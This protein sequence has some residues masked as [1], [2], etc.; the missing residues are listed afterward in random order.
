MDVGCGG[1]STRPK[2]VEDATHPRCGRAGDQGRAVRGLVPRG[3]ERAARQCGASSGGVL[4]GAFSY[5]PEFAGWRPRIGNS[6]L[7]GASPAGGWET[8]ARPWGRDGSVNAQSL[9]INPTAV[10]LSPTAVHQSPMAVHPIQRR[11]TTLAPTRT[12]PSGR[13]GGRSSGAGCRLRGPATQGF[14]LDQVVLGTILRSCGPTLGKQYSRL[15]GR[16]LIARRFRRGEEGRAPLTSGEKPFDFFQELPGVARLGQEGR[17]SRVHGIQDV[18]RKRVGGQDKN[19]NMVC[20][21]VGADSTGGF[22][23]IH[24]RHGHVHNDHI[25]T[26][27]QCEWKGFRPIHCLHNHMLGIFQHGAVNLAIVTVI[28]DQQN[29]CHPT[30]L[31][32]VT[33]F[34]GTPCCKFH[35]RALRRLR[36]QAFTRCSGRDGRD[37][38]AG[39]TGFEDNPANVR[40]KLDFPSR[41]IRRQDDYRNRGTL[42]VCVQAGRDDRPRCGGEPVIQKDHVR[43]VQAGGIAGVGSIGDG[44]NRV[45]CLRK[46]C[47]ANH[48]GICVVVY[49]Q[50]AR[51]CHWIAFA[52]ETYT[53]PSKM[54]FIECL[55]N[56]E[57]GGYGLGVSPAAQGPGFARSRATNNV[58]LLRRATPADRCADGLQRAGT[59]CLPGTPPGCPGPAGANPSRGSSQRGNDVAACRGGAGPVVTLA[60]SLSPA[61][62]SSLR[63]VGRL[64]RA[65]VGGSAPHTPTFRAAGG[66][67]GGG[68][69]PR[70]APVRGLGWQDA[71]AR[72][73]GTQL[74]HAAGCNTAT[75]TCNNGPDHC[76]GRAVRRVRE[77]ENIGDAYVIRTYKT[78]ARIA[79]TCYIIDVGCARHRSRRRT[80]HGAEY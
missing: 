55:H 19:G 52:A 29:L 22:Q 44:R 71:P 66:S 67:G 36:G 48:N 75:P 50:H 80:G 9:L 68:G 63:R 38:P 62:A 45:A 57:G 25:R 18:R 17:R 31:A 32:S 26:L 70:R 51:G 46:L 24:D 64:R 4:Q 5:A 37:K 73:G 74:V 30:M 33:D 20:A 3:F 2:V 61:L 16:P 58:A 41:G 65:F 10:H 13:I 42:R 72:P 7:L 8:R 47:A 60:S 56:A 14:A 59:G 53:P 69:A 39:L 54:A 78:I 35:A 12:L 49:D 77:A 21:G 1:G 11:A 43:H 28:L 79:I 76:K 6:E 23:S 34:G 40:G 15:S 27:G